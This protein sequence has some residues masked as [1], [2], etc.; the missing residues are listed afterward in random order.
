MAGSVAPVCVVRQYSPKDKAAVQDMMG[1]AI[2]ETVTDYFWAAVLSEVSPQVALLVIAF[3]FIGLGVPFYFCLLGIPAAVVIIYVVVWA[4]HMSRVLEVNQELG[5]IPQLFLQQPSGNFWVA[6]VMETSEACELDS[7]INK[8]KKVEYQFMSEDEARA[9]QAELEGLKRH[10]VGMVG[11]TKSLRGG[12]RNRLKH[13]V[14]K[15]A[16]R[17]RGIAQGLVDEAVQ[18]STDHCMEGIELVTTECHHKA[19]ELF[20]RKGFEVQ[21]TYYKYYLNVQ[22]PVYLF[23]LPLKPPKA[24]LSE[25]SST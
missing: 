10:V 12:M 14:V 11:V 25:I 17:R 16:Y 23:S 3:A 19:R 7:L 2:M 24:E 9:K 18:F 5:N 1:Q 20:Y 15:K 6:E 8:T 13:L 4:A 21:H 22:Q